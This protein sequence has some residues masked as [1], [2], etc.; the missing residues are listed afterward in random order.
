MESIPSIPFTQY[1]KIAAPVRIGLS[2]IIVIQFF[3]IYN[4]PSEILYPAAI[5]SA[6]H[7][8]SIS[9]ERAKM[10]TV[11]IAEQR[12]LR[13]NIPMYSKIIKCEKCGL[14]FDTDFEGE[15]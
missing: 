2:A 9:Y 14:Q 4:I 15:K 5:L 1:K 3:G 13:C 8:I 10:S 11:E 6:L 12:C 7:L